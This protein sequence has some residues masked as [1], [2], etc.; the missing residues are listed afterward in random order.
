MYKYLVI[1]LCI[2]TLGLYHRV[3][4][5]PVDYLGIA[6]VIIAFIA[7]IVENINEHIRS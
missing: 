3:D 2:I 5:I 6:G 1:L 7:V 4:L